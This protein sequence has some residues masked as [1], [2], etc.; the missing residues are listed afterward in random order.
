LRRGTLFRHVIA[1]GGGFGP[2]PEREPARVLE[3][4]V[5]GKVSA[6]QA[7]AVYR[8]AVAGTDSGWRIDAAETERLRADAS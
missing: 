8:V 7:R 4:V 2:P 3:D 6:E 5:L 1:S